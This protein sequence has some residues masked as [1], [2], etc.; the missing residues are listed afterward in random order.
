MKMGPQRNLGAESQSQRTI[1][2]VPKSW[3]M[4]IIIPRRRGGTWEGVPVAIWCSEWI[5]RMRRG[6]FHHTIMIPLRYLSRCCEVLAV[7]RA[8]TIFQ[9][10]WFCTRI[11]NF[12]QSPIFAI[13]GII[14]GY[15]YIYMYTT[16]INR[17]KM[18]FAKHRYIKTEPMK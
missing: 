1:Q 8:P 12:F 7:G 15:A 3:K 6:L 16:K 4:A 13:T 17:T 9:N 18:M 2:L 10:D 14:H 5:C 11:S